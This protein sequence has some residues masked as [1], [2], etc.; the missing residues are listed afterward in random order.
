MRLC[1][2]FGILLF[3]LLVSR[4]GHFSHSL[5]AV[6]VNLFSAEYDAGVV[7]ERASTTATETDHLK[8]DSAEGATWKTMAP[9]A[10]CDPRDV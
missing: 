9:K 6:R 4:T 10:F 2:A 8:G 1:L 5:L 7:V 3:C